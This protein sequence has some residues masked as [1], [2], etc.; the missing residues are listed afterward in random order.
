MNK[1]FI[2]FYNQELRHIKGK[3][4]EFG[5]A[6]P[7]IG[8]RLGI[9]SMEVADP[10]VERLLE[11]F[12]FLTARIQHKR[13]A[14]FPKFTQ[15]LLEIVYPNFQC[16]LPS[17]AV[18][19]FTPDFT[20]G[21]FSQGVTVPKHTSVFNAAADS[22]VEPCH[23][24]TA[25]EC[26]FQPVEVNQV[27][28]K[29][30]ELVDACVRNS[31]VN[32]FSAAIEVELNLTAG[33]LANEVAMEQLDFFIAG[34]DSLAATLY[35]LLFS[36]CHEV[37][38]SGEHKGQELAVS[39]GGKALAPLGFAASESLLP[40][41]G[42]NLNSFRILQEYFALPQ[43]FMFVRVGLL[44]QALKKMDGQKLTLHFLLD[45][46][47][48]DL[49]RAV[50]KNYF[51]LH[52]TPIVNLFPKRADRTKVDFK[53]TEF[54][55]I[56]DRTKPLDFEV[57][58]INRVLGYTG[59]NSSSR[60]F[61]PFYG[62]TE[63]SLDH[64]SACFYTFAREPRLF[65]SAKKQQGPRSSYLGSDTRIS[66]VDAGAAPFNEEIKHLDIEVLC[67]NRDLP[68][69]I[70]VGQT[71][72]DFYVDS[73]IPVESIQI[74]A[75]PTAPKPA[76]AA[77]ETNWKLINHLSSHYSSL[78]NGSP[79]QNADN[80]KALLRLYSD[81]H[82]VST[83]NMISSLQSITNTGVVRKVFS[84]EEIA[85]ARGINLSLSFDETRAELGELFLFA[86]VLERFLGR[87]VSINS[88]IEMQMHTVTHGE[89]KKWPAR[90]CQKNLV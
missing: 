80:L 23:F 87:Y 12:A 8:A 39:L 28:Y 21:N 78:I 49:Q 62:T 41:A 77:S 83:T 4:Q 54:N 84:G 66:L 40:L 56:P 9:E 70:Q 88:F 82:S 18:V 14:Q 52:C 5:A 20:Q 48:V 3:A 59:D 27:H 37:V 71:Q 55:V 31:V 26:Q 53:K 33:L 10:Y 74:L 25:H 30:A 86:Q 57:H 60:E 58:S 43:R 38:V 32:Q 51:K 90:I 6:Y 76:L 13:D 65:S 35:R 75:G 19:E 16:P 17:M 89:V 72:S 34:N 50:N 45:D 63:R 22:D 11:S 61:L 47:S 7:K 15:N 42:K 73:G 24:R 2:D 46:A 79:T 29:L 44:Q 67:T 1:T 69:H 85:Y 64:P 81:E 36:K 68:L